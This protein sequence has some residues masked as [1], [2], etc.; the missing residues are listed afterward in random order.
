[1]STY[2]IE[3][4]HLLTYLGRDGHFYTY[5]GWGWS[6]IY[7]YRRGMATYLIGDGRERER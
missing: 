4:E 3:D 5:I 7:L 1:M 6:L 2:P